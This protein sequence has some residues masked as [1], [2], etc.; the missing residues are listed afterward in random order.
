[1]CIRDRSFIDIFTELRAQ[2]HDILAILISEKL[3][4]TIASANQALE[5]MPEEPVE[6]FDSHSTAMA[7]GFQVL[8][9]ARAGEQ[10]AKLAECVEVARRARESTGVIFAVETL[11]FLHRG[12]RIGGASR[13]LGTALNIK[14]ILEVTEEGV[15]EAVERVRTRKKS[16]SRLV[17]LLCE[18]VKGRTPVHLAVLHANAPEEARQLMEQAAEALDPVETV[19]STVSPVVGTHAGPGTVGLAYLAGM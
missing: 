13:L 19:L 5:L 17:E 11:E 16:L 15:V 6:I 1:M 3:S 9:A 8:A 18:R 4:G 14:P 12:G 2:D 10:G 7:M